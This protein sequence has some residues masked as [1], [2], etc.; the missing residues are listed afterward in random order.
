M[1]FNWFQKN[2][3]Y[4]RIIWLSV[5]QLTL[6]KLVVVYNL[7]KYLQNVQKAKCYLITGDH[8]RE[9]FASSNVRLAVIKTI[10]FK[11]LCFIQLKFLNFIKNLSCSK[12]KLFLINC[13]W[14]YLM[15]LICISFIFYI[16]LSSVSKSGFLISAF[17]CKFCFTEKNLSNSWTKFLSADFSVSKN[18]N[19][20]SVF[21]SV[22]L[23]LIL[24]LYCTVSESKVN[25]KRK[26]SLI[27][28]R[29]INQ[30]VIIWRPLLYS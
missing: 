5:L 13:L 14:K 4:N 8:L 2:K 10:F 12:H 19:T 21:C 3:K 26:K 18:H 30:V 23:H 1:H 29:N 9:C 11:L 20:A 22:Q 28:Y 17:F 27:I 24:R 16:S 15:S 6:L 25:E 7:K